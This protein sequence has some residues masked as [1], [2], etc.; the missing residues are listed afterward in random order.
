MPAPAL[1][2]RR[3][4]SFPARESAGAKYPTPPHFLPHAY[5]INEVTSKKPESTCE[6]KALTDGQPTRAYRSRANRRLRNHLATP[7]PS[8]KPPN[9][10]HI[11]VTISANQ[12]VFVLAPV[13]E[14]PPSSVTSRIPATI[15]D[16]RIDA[17]HCSS[18]RVPSSGCAGC[19]SIV[20]RFGG[21]ADIGIPNL[22]PVAASRT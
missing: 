21:L 2:V 18:C 6:N 12:P 20:P 3:P 14:K 1:A 13:G 11:R 9:G 22:A 15:P 19:F 17:P 5:E 16:P 4:D 10:R 8:S 7:R